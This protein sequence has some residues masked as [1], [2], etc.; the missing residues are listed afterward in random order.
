[1]AEVPGITNVVADSGYFSLAAVAAVEGP[2]GPT[3]CIAT[4]KTGHHRTVADLLAS[5]EPQRPVSRP[6][7]AEGV[8]HRLRTAIGRAAYKKRKKTVEP[9]PSCRLSPF[10]SS[11]GL[12][13][14]P[15]RR[16]R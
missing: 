15:A 12:A 11:K 8:R 4:G 7:D 14:G 6:V 3:V 9:V 13:Q 2:E 5:P 16:A 1:M 10:S